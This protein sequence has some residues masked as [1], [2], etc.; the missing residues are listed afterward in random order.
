[1]FINVYTVINHTSADFAEG[2]Q[3]C[4]LVDNAFKNNI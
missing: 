1:M 2:N 4:E 3:T